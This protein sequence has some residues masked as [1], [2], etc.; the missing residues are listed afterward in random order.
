[1]MLSSKLPPLCPG[2]GAVSRSILHQHFGYVSQNTDY[3]LRHVQARSTY[4]YSLIQGDSSGQILAF[5]DFDFWSSAVLPRCSAKFAG[6]QAE[7]EKS[8]STKA[9]D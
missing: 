7:I 2:H 1:M 3:D 6:A 4:N 8:L 9:R 5:V